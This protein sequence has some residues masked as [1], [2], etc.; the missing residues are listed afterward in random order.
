[1]L[2]SSSTLALDRGFYGTATCGVAKERHESLR[3]GI[4]FETS[5]RGYI[6]HCIVQELV[7]TYHTIL[8]KVRGVVGAFRV[9]QHGDEEV[10][11]AILESEL[12]Q[13]VEY[14]QGDHC[15]PSESS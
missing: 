5:L 4:C 13:S 10:P 6:S 3:H 7:S 8:P 1:M 12:S 14:E 9:K 2:T 11:D 15:V